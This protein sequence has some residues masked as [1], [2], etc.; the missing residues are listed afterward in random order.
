M[1]IVSPA[2]TAIR[3]EYDSQVAATLDRAASAQ[4]AELQRVVNSS[5]RAWHSTYVPPGLIK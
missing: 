1:K 3:R 4:Q 2:K 5:T